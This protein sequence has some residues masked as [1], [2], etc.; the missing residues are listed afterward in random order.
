MNHNQNINYKHTA[1]MAIFHI[2]PRVQ[3]SVNDFLLILPPI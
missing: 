1:S 2:Y 3:W